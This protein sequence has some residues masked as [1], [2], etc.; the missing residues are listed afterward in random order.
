MATKVSRV[1]PGPVSLPMTRKG[2]QGCRAVN[3]RPLALGNIESKSHS[4]LLTVYRQ[5]DVTPVSVRNTP[6]FPH[7]QGLLCRTVY[8][9]LLHSKSS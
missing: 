8:F 7:T 1:T 2:G 5:N 9:N 3:E 4:S 6:A